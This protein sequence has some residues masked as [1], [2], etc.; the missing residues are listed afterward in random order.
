MFLVCKNTGVSL[1]APRGEAVLTDA[2]CSLVSTY[3][4]HM[5]SQSF[6]DPSNSTI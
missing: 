1:G 3:K 2:F 5:I 6:L 4:N